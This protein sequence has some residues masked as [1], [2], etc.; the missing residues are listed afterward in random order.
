MWSTSVAAVTIPLRWHSAH[1]GLLRLNDSEYDF[2]ACVLYRLSAVDL[3]VDSD[4]WVQYGF[5]DSKI[6]YAIVYAAKIVLF[7]IVNHNYLNINE[8]SPVKL[9]L[10]GF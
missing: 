3:R 1:S 5:T 9:N 10:Q 7:Y 2:H 8:K 4:C 6:V